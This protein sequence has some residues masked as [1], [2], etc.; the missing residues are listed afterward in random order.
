[1]VQR[2]ERQQRKWDNLHKEDTEISDW[3]LRENRANY[4]APEYELPKTNKS[5]ARAAEN[6]QNKLEK[7][8]KEWEALKAMDTPNMKMIP[9]WRARELA[10]EIEMKILDEVEKGT[11]RITI[12]DNLRR[13]GYNKKNILLGMRRAFGM[14][15]TENM[16]S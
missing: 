7:E 11:K 5:K 3:V 6:I 9:E 15:I 4:V 2:K 10:K 16:F 14:H 13:E 8:R 1:M 12:Y